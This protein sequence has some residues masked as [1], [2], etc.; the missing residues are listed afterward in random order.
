MFVGKLVNW[1]ILLVVFWENIIFNFKRAEIR[2]M[3]EVF[4]AK[5]YCKMSDLFRWF[6]LALRFSA[7]NSGIKKLMMYTRTC[8][9]N[10]LEKKNYKYEILNH[11]YFGSSPSRFSQ[12]FFLIFRHRSTMV[13]DIF[14]QHP[15]P[16]H[17]IKKVSYDTEKGD[18]CPS[19]QRGFFRYDDFHHNNLTK[20]T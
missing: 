14:N 16:L 9:N 12:C 13:V 6:L 3:S 1:E 2:K 7:T 19:Q 8:G 17:T 11:L 20:S 4:C 5:L 10:R 18:L 15:P